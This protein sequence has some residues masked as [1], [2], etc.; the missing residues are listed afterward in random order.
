MSILQFYS[1]RI[2]YLSQFSAAR[3][4][5]VTAN[6]DTRELS[7]PEKIGFHL[8]ASITDNLH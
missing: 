7:I 1:L 3:F 5:I 4:A 6:G 8:R 2:R